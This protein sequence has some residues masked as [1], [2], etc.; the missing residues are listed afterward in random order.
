[1]STPLEN[2]Q[3]SVLN[4]GKILSLMKESRIYWQARK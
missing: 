3:N 4:Q 2:M 1:M